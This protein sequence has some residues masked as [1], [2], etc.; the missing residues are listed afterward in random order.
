MHQ[1]SFLQKNISKFCKFLKNEL[2]NNIYYSGTHEA[3]TEFQRFINYH[4][5]KSFNKQ[6]FTLTY[7]NRYSWMTSLLRTKMAGKKQIV[8]KI[9]QNPDNI[10]LN[11]LYKRKNPNYIRIK[12]YRNFLL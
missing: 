5:N 8:L 3:F 4:S 6:T 12:K 11:R 2:W 10:E 1:M 9:Q 7:K